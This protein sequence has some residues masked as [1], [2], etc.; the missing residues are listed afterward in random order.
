VIPPPPRPATDLELQLRE[1]KRKFEERVQ[2]AKDRKAS[3]AVFQ[4]L[5]VA[6]R[7]YHQLNVQMQGIEK[8]L[9]REEADRLKEKQLRDKLEQLKEDGKRQLNEQERQLS[10][11]Y[12]GKRL[13]RDRLLNQK[14]STQVEIENC[15]SRHELKKEDCANRVRQAEAE[16]TKQKLEIEEL[17][18]TIEDMSATLRVDAAVMAER[19]E[20]ELPKPRRP[21][22]APPQQTALRVPAERRAKLDDLW[23]AAQ[24][25][26][27]THAPR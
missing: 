25:T 23:K 13:E 18:A 8:E 27:M 16:L 6:T 5:L 21:P 22:P 17:R 4:K 12:E 19:G 14:K 26:A 20:P 1:W 2:E 15:R 24:A 3:I 9:Q 7:R 11:E 10:A